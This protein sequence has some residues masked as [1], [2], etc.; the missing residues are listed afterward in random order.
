MLQGDSLQ[1]NM[2]LRNRRALQ[3]LM[4]E[5]V[6][7]VVVSPQLVK[8]ICEEEINEEYLNYLSELNK[9]L[10]HVKQQEMQKLP[11]C[12]QSAPELEKLRTKAV[13]RIK[14]FLLQKI[15][16]LKKPK[17][18]LQILQRNVLVRF[19][20]FTQFLQEH[21][22]GVATEVKQHYVATMSK[23]Y[24]NQFRTYVSTL[25]KLELEYSPKKEDLLVSYDGQSGSAAGR[26]LDNLG[27]GRGPQLKD[28][29]SG[30]KITHQKSQK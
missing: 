14:D 29:G 7:S 18:N 23:V 4:S 3:S 26:F 2:K 9:K 8:Q 6:N 12:A 17:T 15:M 13:S 19:K 16:A 11:S 30:Q 10:D 22:P 28:Q 21:H 5:Y 1:M 20:F 27:L 24:L 25:Q